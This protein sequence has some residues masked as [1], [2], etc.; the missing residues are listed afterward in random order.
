MKHST[1]MDIL[2]IIPHIWMLLEAP[3]FPDQCSLSVNSSEF[4]RSWEYTK[5][6]MVFEQK[7]VNLNLKTYKTNGFQI[8]Y[9]MWI[10]SIEDSSWFLF[11]NTYDVLYSSLKSLL[12]CRITSVCTPLSSKLVVDERSFLVTSAS[13]LAPMTSSEKRNMEIWMNIYLLIARWIPEITDI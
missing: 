12:C 8:W 6:F 3:G 1:R 5:V 4:Y 9:L 11:T 7:L 10:F 13:P 2:P